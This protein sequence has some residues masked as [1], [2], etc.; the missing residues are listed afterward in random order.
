[1]NSWIEFH[2]LDRWQRLEN[3][4]H[5]IGVPVGGHRALGDAKAAREVLRWLA[6]QEV[7]INA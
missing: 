7:S 5:N 6:R 2:G 1:M 3:V 4:C